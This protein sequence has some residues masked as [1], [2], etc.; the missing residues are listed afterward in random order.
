[1][2][3]NDRNYSVLPHIL[4]KIK[5]KSNTLDEALVLRSNFS[6]FIYKRVLLH[7]AGV[8]KLEILATLRITTVRYLFFHFSLLLLALF[9]DHSTCSDHT[10]YTHT[11]KSMFLEKVVTL[12]MSYDALYNPEKSKTVNNNSKTIES[13]TYRCSILICR[14]P[15]KM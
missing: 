11:R 6:N 12:R 7:D 3:N 8:E 9:P 13:Q 5:L 4:A 1:M 14:I 15:I 10:L 2:L